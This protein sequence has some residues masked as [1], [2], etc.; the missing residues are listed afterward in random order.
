ML[1]KQNFRTP[2]RYKYMT[3]KRRLV[4]TV[5]YDLSGI[6]IEEM[7]KNNNIEY[8]QVLKLNASK[9]GWVL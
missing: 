4:R 1:V 2:E 8:Q 6:L 3:F 5:A 7:K 9:P